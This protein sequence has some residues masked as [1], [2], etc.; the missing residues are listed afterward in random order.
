MEQYIEESIQSMLNQTERLFELIIVD[1]GSTDS[2]VDIIQKFE[3][4]RIKLF[5]FDD[6]KGVSA[7]R[8]YAIDRAE[9]D[10]I[11]F[12]DA[13]DISLPNR[14]QQLKE[15]FNSGDIV[16]AH[17]D[18]ILFNSGIENDLFRYVSSMQLAHTKATRFFLKIGSPFHGA[19][20]MIRKDIAQ[21]I[22]YD[23][24]LTVGEDTDYIYHLTKL[25]NGVHIPVALY[26]YR[27]HSLSTTYKI[28][29]DR[30]IA[31]VEKFLNSHEWTDLI[32]EASSG[33][34]ARAIIS[35]FLYR[36]GL[37]P[38]SQ[39]YYDEAVKMALAP[40]EKNVISGL[41]YLMLNKLNEALHYLGNY[42]NS[43]AVA[44]N[45]IGEIFA[46][47]GNR[48]AAF[49]YFRKALVLAPNYN[50]PLEN[51][52]AISAAKEHTMVD[53]TFNKFTGK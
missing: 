8:N 48:G 37:I 7:A 26:L 47:D 17:S 4:D 21:S 46:Q 12:Q 39:K 51:I 5:I 11:V 30:Y 41:G 13:D 24:S 23:E 40:Y 22:K 42:A 29:Y 50:E 49:E 35:L 18:L 43:S 52:K 25:G 34:E 20:L 27:R 44:C 15:A 38:L 16:F 10:Y 3:D 33:A 6:H 1:D 19:T 28:E 2:T 9:G 53:T 14:L 36:R 45:Y 31:H 32:P